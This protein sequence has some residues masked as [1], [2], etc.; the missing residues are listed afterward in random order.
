VVRYNLKALIAEK[1]FKENKKITREDI[2]KETGISKTT[3]SMIASK[4]GYVTNTSN[5][6][7]LC[8]YFEV[9]P[10]KLISIIPDQ[11]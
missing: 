7:K 2:S 11:K 5:I 1:S 6:E 10:D 3:L 9:N 8:N 4:K